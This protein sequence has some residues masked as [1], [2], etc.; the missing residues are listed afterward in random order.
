ME[1]Q[2]QGFVLATKRYGEND[3]IVDALTQQHGRHAG[4]IRG[5]A[6]SKRMRGVLTHGNLVNLI[7]RARLSEQLGSW[8][9]ELTTAY[10]ARVMD[11]A[12]ALDAL[13]TLCALTMTLPERAPAPKIFDLFK[14][15]INVLSESDLWPVLLA[16]FE[17]VLLA[18]LG[19]GLDLSAARDSLTAFISPQGKVVVADLSRAEAKDK[20]LARVPRFWVENV[21]PIHEEIVEALRLT[22][23]FF[24][25]RVYRPRGQTLPEVRRQLVKKLKQVNRVNK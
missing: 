23:W 20:E 11:D 14:N 5:A 12:L 10:A 6:V 21:E 8:R 13:N 17:L 22:M 1:W 7:W 25:Q 15:L 9:A 18:E 4:Y 16:Q 3:M 2:D 24:D 19:F